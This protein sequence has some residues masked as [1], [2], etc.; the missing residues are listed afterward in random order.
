MAECSLRSHLYGEG[1]AILLLVQFIGGLHTPRP[2]HMLGHVL[3]IV[4]QNPVR[5][6]RN[7]A[8]EFVLPL[9]LQML[10]LIHI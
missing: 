2:L 9:S 7:R 1:V 10:S 3:I 4:D 5:S 6:E 8:G